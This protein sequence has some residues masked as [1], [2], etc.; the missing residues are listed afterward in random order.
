MRILSWNC[1]GLGNPWTVRD[2]CRL[3]KE[4]K[5]AMVFI[6]ETK[7]LARKLE[8]IKIKV[9]FTNLFGVDNVGKSGGL[10]LLWNNEVNVEIQN[11]SRRH[12]NAVVQ[13]DG[14]AQAWKFTGFYGHPDTSKRRESWSLLKYLH[15][16]SPSS[17]LC[18][19]DF[20]EILE[21]TE[22]WGGR[23]KALRQ[24]RDFQEVVDFCHF[25][26]LGFTG[27]RFTWQNGRDE[28][29]FTQER[30]DRAFGNSDWCG[31]FPNAHVEV[32]VARNSDHA[33]ICV[34]C[35]SSRRRARNYVHHFKYEA[36]WSKKEGPKEII[37]QAWRPKE[38]QKNS[39]QEIKLNM[40]DSK[41]E[42]LRW[43][44]KEVQ[45]TCENIAK[46][47]DL[48]CQL[49]GVVGPTRRGEIRKLQAE[50]R[51]LLEQEDMMWRQRAKMHWMKE[52]DKNTRFFHECV[53]QRRRRNYISQIEDEDGRMRV[54]QN[55]VEQAFSSYFQNLFTSSNPVRVEESL[56]LLPSRVSAD[57][58]AGLIREPT[59]E[60]V[61]TAL[62]QMEPM[63]AP[64]P[65]G[66]PT[67]FFQDHWAVVGPKIVKA[68][69]D[70]FRYGLFD[71]ELNFTHIV[72]IPK[73]TEASKVTDFRPISLCNVVYKIISK[74]LANRLKVILPSIISPNQSAFVPGRLIT[75]NILVAY[76][77]LHTMHA[78]MWGKVG[79]MA[80]KLDMSKA[81][82]RVEWVFLEAVMR[83]MG[84]DEK[85]VSLVMSCISSV[86]YS[87][88]ING[89]PVG[90][91]YPSR[92]IRQGDPISP[93]L[94]LLCAEVLSFK[95][96]QAASNGSLRGVPTSPRG[97]KINHLFFADDSLIFCKAN[98][99]EWITLA[100][101]LDEYEAV[102]GQRLNKD[103]TAVF[104]SRNTSRETKSQI[105]T[106]SGV[107]ISQRYDTYL[108]LPALVGRSRIREFQNIKEKV[109]KRV[110]DWKA[111]FLSQAGK[112][113]LIKAVIQAIPAYSM[114]IFLL[115]KMLCSELN[116]IMQKFWW[117]D[118]EN[119]KKIHWMCWEKMSRSKTQGGMGFRDLLCF[120][121]ALLAKH[122]LD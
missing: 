5:P 36:G 40:K 7:L 30:L 86:K 120:N 67:C 87:I 51:E 25:Q 107:P 109:I 90:L 39:W 18:A 53:K 37:K 71:E 62:S 84:F 112:E 19:G 54:D 95:L 38:R 50:L 122:V 28:D 4:K 99:Q 106:I 74:V 9:G 29:S 3:V 91:I 68:V 94:F 60:E 59:L 89:E 27:P 103:K 26:D 105:Q 13:L 98:S 15:Q 69:S 100:E 49:Q 21:E 43:R 34:S 11:Y 96:Q 61:T 48:L 44:R 81:Y 14:V 64:G 116:G 93:Y 117:G 41:R 42:L 33:P 10:A 80:L 79:Y 24:M 46:K 73:K 16:L 72:L 97:P 75:D 22:K 66:F 115:P 118:N 77:T 78:R 111:K 104:F 85:W 101:I 45:P 17:W 82:D 12:I 20:N 6:M 55:E 63:K 47:S 119:V 2:L 114:S 32:V 58:N 56:Q 52:G 83:K 113:V 70:F 102:S 23:R 57:M 1:R 92:G 31:L 121:K 76:E 108:G 65:D 8:S 35:Y 110:N 88:I